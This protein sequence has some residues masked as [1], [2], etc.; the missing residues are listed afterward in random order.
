MTIREQYITGGL[1]LF[2]RLWAEQYALLEQAEGS[3]QGLQLCQ[4]AD[5]VAVIKKISLIVRVHERVAGQTG[6]AYTSQMKE[7][8]GSM[9]KLYQLFST[10]IAEFTKINGEKAVKVA[11]IKQMIV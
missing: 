6:L 10:Y 7:A 8:Y 5:G 11:N 1:E 9:L 4:N 2:N 3:G